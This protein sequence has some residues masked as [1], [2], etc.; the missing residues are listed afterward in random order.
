MQQGS[1][2]ASFLSLST[3]IPGMSIAAIGF[4]LAMYTYE[5][6]RMSSFQIV[7]P[8]TPT[9]ILSSLIGLGLFML[10]TFVMYSIRP[11]F[12]LHRYIF[13]GFII[14]GLYALVT[15]FLTGQVFSFM[16]GNTVLIARIID[17]AC[18]LLLL[19]CWAEVLIPLGARRVALLFGVSLIA[20]GCINVLTALIKTETTYILVAAFPLIS[21]AC[22]YWFKDRS[23]SLDTGSTKKANAFAV[24]QLDQSLMTGSSSIASKAS[25]YLIFLL[26]LLCYPFVFGHIH[27]TWLP[28]QDGSLFSLSVQIAAAAGTVFGGIT[29][30]A[31]TLFF[32]GRRKL[33]LYPLIVLPIALLALY[34]AGLAGNQYA[35]LSV[36]PLN[37]AQKL[38]FAFV[39]LSPFLIASKKSPMFIWCFAVSLYQFGKILST[40]ASGVSDEMFYTICVLVT[41]AV[42]IIGFLVGLLMDRGSWV[43]SGQNNEVDISNSIR[44]SITDNISTLPEV[45]IP[46]DDHLEIEYRCSTIARAHQ[47]TRREEEVLQL[48]AEGMNAQAIAEALVV[49]TSTA[50]SHM[51]NIYAKL[52]IHTQSELLILVRKIQ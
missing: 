13:T 44:A 25:L 39:W 6:Y 15:L 52:E 3:S 40:S 21:M 10:F 14:A 41:V 22:L 24:F 8:S 48:L 29:L 18:K 27:Y 19:L 20:L 36:I 46:I 37:I 16:G 30:I 34:L 45:E 2:K 32:W 47:L 42:L 31:L 17:Y 26:P 50:K 49:S 23:A 38:I 12:R 7:E 51:R 43:S 35:S 11:S 4:A 33:Q 9:T 5:A 28:A 1:L